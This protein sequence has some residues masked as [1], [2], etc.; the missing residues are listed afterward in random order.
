MLTGHY[1]PRPTEVMQRFRF[2]S[3]AR[4]EGESV[5]EYV[6]ELRKLAEFCN[7]GDSLNNMLRDRLVWGMRDAGIQKKLL[8]EPDLTLDRAIRIAQ[9]TETAEQNLKEMDS[10]AH[11]A[12]HYMSKKQYNGKRGESSAIKREDRGNERDYRC[13]RC[14]KTGHDEWECYYR[15]SVCHNCKNRGHLAKVCKK[16]K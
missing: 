6:A 11:K 15:D 5:A 7:Y 1:S 10:E 2:N 3:R 13:F 8:S 14:G 4:K 12:I 16:T 9:S